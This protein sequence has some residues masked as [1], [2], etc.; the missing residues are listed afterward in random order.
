MNMK[1]AHNKTDVHL[2]PWNI[3]L[4]ACVAMLMFAAWMPEP[5][6][7]HD[8][9]AA[10]SYLILFQLTSSVILGSTATAI[11][12]C[13]SLSKD[14][15]MYLSGVALLGV[16]A[17][18]LAQIFSTV[19]ANADSGGSLRAQ[20]FS[21]LSSSLLSVC[22]FVL[23][24][25]R[26][27]WVCRWV[28]ASVGAFLFGTLTLATLLPVEMV[29]RVNGLSQVVAG[30]AGLIHLGS[31]FFLWRTFRQGQ[32]SSLP[33][34]IF[35]PLSFLGGNLLACQF[36][37]LSGW[38]TWVVQGLALLGD[39][40]L[41]LAVVNAPSIK[42]A[43]GKHSPVTDELG[44]GAQ[45][46]ALVDSLSAAMVFQLSL[47]AEN[48]RHFIVIGKS[49]LP[50]LGFEAMQL[51]AD[52]ELFFQCIH[53]D[54]RHLVPWARP[55]T[56]TGFNS[57]EIE[58]RFVRPDRRLKWLQIRATPR[59]MGEG[60]WVVDGVVIDIT[61][62]M[63]FKEELH[64]AQSRLARLIDAA[65]DA[66]LM[67][68]SDQ[69]VISINRAALAMFRCD[70]SQIL[71]HP[72]HVLLPERFRADH[73]SHISRF[74]QSGVTN[75]KMGLRAT[76]W[77]L[78]FDGEEFP[79][80]ASI[81][82][83]DFEGEHLLTVILSDVTEVVATKNSLMKAKQ[84][85][86]SVLHSVGEGLYLMDRNG[87]VTFINPA[88]A[89]L[90]GYSDTSVTGRPA[91]E[92]FHHSHADG[93]VYR[94]ADSRIHRSL[95]QL[96]PQL[97]DDEVFWRQDGSCFSAQYSC[98]PIL[99]EGIITGVVVTFRDIDEEQRTKR[100]LIDSET[101]L[102][103][104]QGIAGFG[105]YVIDLR[106]GTWES[107]SQLDVLFGVHAGYER[108]LSNWY[109]LVHPDDRQRVMLHLQAVI[110]GQATLRIDYPIVRLQDQ[111]LCWVAA[112]GELEYGADGRPVRLIGTIQDITQRKEAE[113]ALKESHDLL[114]KLAE[115]VPGMLYQLKLSAEG[116]YSMPFTS[117]GVVDLFELTPVQV[118][119]SANALFKLVTPAGREA[120][121]ESITKSARLLTDWSQEFQVELPGRPLRWYQGHSRPELQS[122]GS[123][124]WHGFIFDATERIEVKTQLQQLNETLESR[125]T[126]RTA[127]LA[128]AL[129]HAEVAKRSRGEFL[130]KVSH[131]I[132]TPM[133]SILGSTY[134]ALQAN[135]NPVMSGYLKRIEVSARHLLGIISDILDFSKIDAR[136]LELEVRDFEM[137]LV[138]GQVMA[139]TEGR[140][141]EKGLRLDVN[142]SA[143][144]P[145]R[146]R[147]DPLRLGQVLINYVSN[148]VKFTERG[149]VALQVHRI[150]MPPDS[151]P[152]AQCQLCFEVKDTGIGMSEE[153]QT[154]LFQSFEQGDNSV[155]RKFGGT[156]L[157]LAICKQLVELMGGQVGVSSGP[158]RGS[159]FWFTALFELPYS[160]HVEPQSSP[161]VLDLTEIRGLHVLVV[162]DND[163]NL[164]VAKDILTAVG[165]EVAVAEDGQQALNALALKQFNAVLMDVQ[166]PVMDGLEATR[167]IRADP[168]LQGTC[169]I[170]MTANASAEDRRH[171]LEAG[172]QDVVTK[173]VEPEVLYASILR[174]SMKN[175][176]SV[177][178]PLSTIQPSL[179]QVDAGSEGYQHLAVW[180]VSSLIR[181][182]GED[183]AVHRRLLQK[184][185]DSSSRLVSE[186]EL[187]QGNRAYKVAGSLA[188][189]LKS[190][191]RTVG[192]LQL[193][194]LCESLE[195]FGGVEDRQA[196]EALVENLRLNHQSV[197]AAIQGWLDGS[198]SNAA[199]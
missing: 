164:A 127:E 10:K 118:K 166:M 45:L 80:D 136:K 109:L 35:A 28:L 23:S 188:H 20:L 68:N 177:E 125:V 159:R 148:A 183:S 174:H 40:T 191:A 92:T 119:S 187:A 114:N 55:S 123:V 171:C 38:Q 158:G 34:I 129:Q 110:Q 134:L 151:G 147:G 29:S 24:F 146:L 37:T 95:T 193:G 139:L 113:Q 168:K 156:G 175:G 93:S 133:N 42:S 58:L 124:V 53:P 121:D 194:A 160:S 122:D 89:R 181:S 47:D 84:F 11:F 106:S 161:V 33:L 64:K 145:R 59:S 97:V 21:M 48:L 18:E 88:G 67:V 74:M 178:I 25:A 130:A 77:G 176:V 79:A 1:H 31:M 182:V 186:I 82:H 138:I 27:R 41:L 198:A 94:L 102:G 105:S 54:D 81:S 6:L 16:V 179:P 116:W 99:E 66:I 8:W 36:S 26:G 169:V 5:A 3:A 44:A 135:A 107:S 152:L 195:H 76:I 173:P 185:L 131:E 190:S 180:D 115:Q 141:V 15:G 104:A 19:A 50:I 163:F 117:R 78:R 46:F 22:I 71:G 13:G 128:L 165:V 52:A 9:V 143:D 12:V 157:G 108:S 154:R 51:K 83:M 155:T 90:L 132:R 2:S 60:C 111:R 126:T 96:E 87:L 149:E 150:T 100:A 30:L 39:C 103:H 184:F 172:M 61:D 98:A 43:V 144:V 69:Q 49:S 120:L 199:G 4:L 56:A 153:Q 17:F 75:R 192:A 112:N 14:R 86:E 70:A 65:M 7:L 140:A 196:C 189:R 63:E 170:G 85:A 167:R 137:E 162:D 142:I 73:A 91:H 62:R 32:C 72:I 101:Q 57:T 197:G